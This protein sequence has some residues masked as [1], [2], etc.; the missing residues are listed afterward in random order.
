MHI[1]MKER[2]MRIMQSKRYRERTGR[3]LGREGTGRGR[4]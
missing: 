4:K 2:M 3:G 1:R